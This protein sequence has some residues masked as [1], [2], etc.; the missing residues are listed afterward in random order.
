MICRSEFV[1]VGLVGLGLIV[2]GLVVMIFHALATLP[3]CLE[4][5]H[6]AG[7]EIPKCRSRI[8]CS[9]IYHDQGKVVLYSN[10]YNI[11]IFYF[12]LLLVR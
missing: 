8:C 4:G 12:L 7:M 3:C 11:R 2:R 9:V 10:S 1:T 6:K 5:W